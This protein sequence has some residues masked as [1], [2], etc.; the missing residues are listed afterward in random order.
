MLFLSLLY[1]TIKQEKEFYNVAQKQYANEINSLLELNDES[2]ISSVV[3]VTFWDEFVNYTKTKDRVWFDENIRVSLDNYNSDYLG[4]YD[5]DGK[6]IDKE[7]NAK[8]KLADFI[9]QESIQ[10]LTSLNL[11]NFSCALL[12]A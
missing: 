7:S 4:A 12:M 3:D 10:K 11:L 8:I 2:K 9:P 6:L 1:Y 5:L